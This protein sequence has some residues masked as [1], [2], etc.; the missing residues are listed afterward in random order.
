MAKTKSFKIL[1]Y[2]GA[3]VR[4][5]RGPLVLDVAGFSFPEQ[6]PVLRQHDH[7]RVVGHGRGKIEQGRFFV[8]GVFSN[9]TADAREIQALIAEGQKFQASVGVESKSVEHVA[10]GVGVSVNG[11]KL[12][13]PAE[14]WRQSWVGEVSVVPWGSDTN[15][16][17][18]ALTHGG[19]RLQLS[20]PTFQVFDGAGAL[21]SGDEPEPRTYGEALAFFSRK[22]HDIDTAIRL[23]K[24]QYP[25]LVEEYCRELFGLAGEHA[26]GLLRS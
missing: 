7:L 17:V 2:S 24:A 19:Q 13:G 3:P 6:V 11:R 16:S 22:G 23:T 21:L 14:V 9:A 8:E 18:V 15:T 10:Q 20:A 25:S 1:G 5:W 12:T 26:Y 4:S